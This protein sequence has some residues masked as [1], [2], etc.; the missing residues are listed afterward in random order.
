MECFSSSICYRPESLADDPIQEFSF[1]VSVV[2]WYDIP[3]LHRVNKISKTLQ[4][5][6][7]DLNVAVDMF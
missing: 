2:F 6:N 5:E 3:V 1:L 4:K 7:A